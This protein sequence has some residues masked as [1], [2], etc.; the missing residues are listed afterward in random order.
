MNDT[1]R[2]LS[3]ALTLCATFSLT[4][5]AD[6][7][8]T[9][10]VFLPDGNPAAKIQ[11]RLFYHHDMTGFGSQWV[12]ETRT[13]DQGGFA[14]VR[15]AFEPPPVIPQMPRSLGY[16][17]VATHP[18]Y[19]MGIVALI[20]N[21]TD[22]YEIWLDKPRRIGFLLLDEN[23]DPMR[24]IEACLLL[25]WGRVFPVG[26]PVTAYQ[27]N[28]E[29]GYQGIAREVYRTKTGDDGSGEFP[30]AF[31][32]ARAIK[33]FTPE[34]GAIEWLKWHGDV[35]ATVRGVANPM[36][37][38]GKVTDAESG[39]PLPNVLVETTEY[40]WEGP[41]ISCGYTITDAKGEYTMR[42]WPGYPT[43]PRQRFMAIDLSQIPNYA[44]KTVSIF[45]ANGVQPDVDITLNRGKLVT[46]KVIDATS[47]KPVAGA[48]VAVDA[49]G[50]P[51]GTA[52]FRLSDAQGNYAFRVEGNR[53]LLSVELAPQGY[54]VL[55]AGQ[56]GMIAL[57][58]Q[59]AEV[60]V[61]P[62]VTISPRKQLIFKDAAGKPFSGIE[63]HVSQEGVDLQFVGSTD[64][65]GRVD[66]VGVGLRTQAGRRGLGAIVNA[67]R[68]QVDTPPPLY[69][70]G[71][72]RDDSVAGWAI[73]SAEELA[74]EKPFEIELKPTRTVEVVLQDERDNELPGTIHAVAELSGHLRAYLREYEVPDAQGDLVA[75]VPFLPGVRY[76]FQGTVR[77]A[78]P[79]SAVLEAAEGENPPRRVMHFVFRQ[80]VVTPAPVP[81]TDF[82]SEVRKLK[83]IL[84]KKEDP[85]ETNLTWYVLKDGFACADS[86]KREVKRFTEVLGETK[87]AVTAIAFGKDRVWLGTNKGLLSW[88]RKN[89][90]W[91]R[92]AVGGLLVD[93]PAK[94][95]LLTD[96]GILKVT[97]EEQGKPQRAFEYDTQ[98]AKWTELK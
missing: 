71:T 25:G 22:G 95:L 56:G 82:A 55:S 41:S 68:G 75:R 58:G 74:S 93:A 5:L 79:T 94:D 19:A 76:A 92:F 30:N 83:D 11:V 21:K 86:Q 44:P 97:V 29:I 35:D 98:T 6:T 65:G 96:A 63:V 66:I 69:V 77:S 91:S 52:Q 57:A 9:G 90:F 32:G 45:E 14:L 7:T 20:P 1:R 13:D 72:A 12:G 43:G 3:L 27:T 2:A 18:E 37:V 80:P 15:P 33:V 89:R 78:Q 67:I 47:G 17:L 39:A 73:I 16:Y 23:G 38:H 51:Q 53:A 61:S 59:T 88:D 28:L 70:Y 46:G 54:V 31:Y 64:G 85:I 87:W 84:W 36:I 42:C 81:S 26:R 40:W 24:N 49:H 62:T 8:L 50:G 10:K 34:F 60:N 48:V 4:A